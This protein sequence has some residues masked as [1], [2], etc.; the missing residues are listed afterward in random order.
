MAGVPYF[1]FYGICSRETRRSKVRSTILAHRWYTVSVNYGNNH[2]LC[3]A[4]PWTEDNDDVWWPCM[5][6]IAEVPFFAF[7]GSC[8]G[9]R[10]KSKVR[11]ITLARGNCAIVGE[12]RNNCT[13]CYA[14]MWTNVDNRNRWWPWVSRLP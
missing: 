2:I 11:S 10:R 4:L 13:V 9:E 14:P 8:G 7:D 1:A 3:Y 6:V 12:M 5:V